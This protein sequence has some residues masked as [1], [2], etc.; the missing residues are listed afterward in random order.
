MLVYD[1]SRHYFHIKIG[2][3]RWSVCG[4]QGGAQTTITKLVDCYDC[5]MYIKVTRKGRK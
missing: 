4:V 2:S 1:N 5:L 3:H